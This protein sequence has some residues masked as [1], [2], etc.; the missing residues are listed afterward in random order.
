[1]T[2]EITIKQGKEIERFIRKKV[3]FYSFGKQYLSITY[4]DGSHSYFKLTTI[5]VIEEV[6]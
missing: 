3:K 2:I 5:L 6:K 4:I 1:M